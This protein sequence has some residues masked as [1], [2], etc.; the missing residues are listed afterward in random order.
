MLASLAVTVALAASGHAAPPPPAVGRC[1]HEDQ[2]TWVWSRCG[3]RKRGLVTRDGRKLVV[4]P[5]AFA[6]LDA[7]GFIDWRVSRRL[8]GDWT[9]RAA[10]VRHYP[11]APESIY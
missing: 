2:P 5:R 4:G 9:A 10:A 7:A 3:N 6:S 11:V 8:R 1:G